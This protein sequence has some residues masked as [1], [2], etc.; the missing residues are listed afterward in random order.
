MASSPHL[1][2]DLPF[3]RGLYP[4]ACWS[5]AFFENAGGSYV[6]ES[7]VGRVTGY[8]RETQ[9][10]PGAGYD[11]SALA[12]ERIAQGQR[13]MAEL[14]GAEPDEVIIGPSTSMNV[15][16]LSRALAGLFGPGD[17]IIVTDLDHEANIGAWRGL[18]G[19]GLTI[20][21]WRLNPDTLA[22]EPE[23]LDELL[24][25]RTRLVCFSHCSNILG[26]INDVARI[27]RR[28]HDAG[29]LV[30]VDGVAFAPHRAVDVKALDV[31]FY[32]VS[33]YK[34]YGPHVSLLYAK[35]EH[36]ER[37]PGQNHY[38]LNDRIPLKLNPGGPNHEFTSALAG[39]ADYFEALADHHLKQP[40]NTFKA[41][42]D[43]VFGLMAAQEE[44]LAA[45]F[46]D[47]LGSKPG[48]RLLGPARADAA[49]RTPTFSFTVEGRAAA[50]IPPLLEPHKI[51]IG[52]GNFYA[53][54]LLEALGVTGNGDE[55]G[56]G[57]VLRVSMAHYNTMDEV[58]RL[59][60]ALDEVL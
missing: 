27:T 24:N 7:V 55:D 3:V 60:A 15:F 51:A 19:D 14:V 32:L 59:I 46:L 8:M 44:T 49:I 53:P 38:F 45:R 39:I 17:E 23:T 40:P 18:A 26:G 11:A 10:Q 50:E 42:A 34:L 56:D 4:A 37:A 12:A 41:R 33:F 57:G 36:L 6:P 25:E 1:D 9:V 5:R 58:D 29:A 30:C 47:F 48:V 21:E 35:R 2:L 16:V 28:V 13:L 54:R 43:R 31:D 22:L 52:Q 20:R